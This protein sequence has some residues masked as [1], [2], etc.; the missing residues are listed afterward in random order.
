MPKIDIPQEVLERLNAAKE[1]AL[2]EGWAHPSLH[3]T[4]RKIYSSWKRTLPSEKDKEIKWKQDFYDAHPGWKKTYNDKYQKEHEEELREKRKANSAERSAKTRE[5]QKAN[6]ERTRKNH[7]K[8]TRENP[9]KVRENYQKRR[10]RINESPVEDLEGIASWEKS[11]KSLPTNICYWCRKDTPTKKCDADHVHAISLQGKH[12]LS[13]LVIACKSCN[14][15][16]K[17]KP[18][19]VWINQLKSEG[20]FILEF[21]NAELFPL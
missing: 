11:W 19:L 18:L 5:W 21:H 14:V 20:L 1:Q 6:P 3:P 9:E 10:A 4:Y 2:K 16:K 13:N 7:L 8:W 15:R 17:N 12:A